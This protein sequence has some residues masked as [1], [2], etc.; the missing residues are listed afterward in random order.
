MKV[1][2]SLFIKGLPKCT[3]RHFAVLLSPD[4]GLMFFVLR[5]KVVSFLFYVLIFSDVAFVLTI[6]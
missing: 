1:S 5:T 3:L 2:V 6:K 4:L